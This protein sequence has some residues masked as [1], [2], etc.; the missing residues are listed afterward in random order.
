M[1]LFTFHSWIMEG[2]KRVWLEPV[3]M[4][5]PCGDGHVLHLD[6]TDINILVFLL[7]YSFESYYHCSKLSKEYIGPVCIISYNCTWIYNYFK[8]K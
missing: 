6:C 3:N 1:I 4:M 2:G 7:Y 5:D 8:I